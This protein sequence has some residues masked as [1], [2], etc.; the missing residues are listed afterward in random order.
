MNRLVSILIAF[1]LLTFLSYSQDQI[2]FSADATI[3]TCNGFMID[4]GGQGG[5]GYSN[6][7]HVVIT[8][9][10]DTPGEMI[11]AVFNL[12]AL[13]G[14]NTGTQQNPNMD[15]MT[16]YDG[17]STA[18]NTL[19]TY[20]NN[21]L[22]GVVIAATQL[23]TSG[24]LTFEFYSNGVGTGSFAGSI[25]CETPCANPQAGGMLSDGISNDSIRVCIN[26]VVNFQESGSMAQPGFNIVDYNW[27]F[28]DGTTANGQ[29]VSH[30][31]STPG[32]YKVQLFV[33]DDNGCTNPN[34]IDLQVLVAP[35]PDFS[36]LPTDTSIC[37]GEQVTFSAIPDSMQITW[38]GFPGSESVD[39]GCITDE[40]LG[41]SQ[42]IDLMQTGFS[43][44]TVIDNVDDIESICLTMEHSFVGD[45]VILITCPNGQS[46]IL[47]QQGGGGTFLGEPV[48]DDNVD[49]DDPATQGEGYSY[50]FTPTATETWVEYVEGN[51]FPTTLPAGDYESVE[52]LDNLVGCPTNGVWTLSV[53]DNW[54]ADDGTLFE[55]GLTLD[56]SYYPDISSFTPDIGSSV[57][58]SFWINPLF[59]VNTSADGNTLTVEPDAPGVYTYTYEVNDDFGCTNSTTIDLNVDGVLD[60]FAGNDT[61]ACFGDVIQ[62]NGS[63][64]NNGP[65]DLTLNLDDTFGDGWNGN[66]ITVTIGGVATNYTLNTGSTQ[67]FTITANAGE[68]IQVV[69]NAEGNFVSECSF[70]IQDNSGNTLLTQGPNLNG[71]T[72]DNIVSNCSPDYT[73]N[74]SPDNLVND[75]SSL[76]SDY[77]VDTVQTL[78]LEGHITGHPLC[79]SFDTVVISPIPTAHPGID[80]SLTTCTEGP[81]TDLFPLLGANVSTPGTWEDPNG[82]NVTMPYDPITW[83]PGTYTY[84][85]D[86]NGCTASATIEVEELVTA[87]T[88]AV[89][90]PTLCFGSSEGSALITGTTLDSYT[91][92]GTGISPAS[93]PFLIDS[94]SAGNY[95]IQ[96]QSIL[97]CTDDTT[98]TIIEPTA[99]TA[100]SIDVDPLCFNYCD[101]STTITPSG[102]TPGYSFT[103]P[104]GINGNQNGGGLGICAGS[105]TVTITDSNN[106]IFDYEFVLINPDSI[107]PDFAFSTL[108]G[109]EP[110]E[111]EFANKTITTD[112]IVQ[113]YFNFGNGYG[114]YEPGLDSAYHMFG[115]SGLYTFSGTVTTEK[116][117][118]FTTTYTDLIDVLPSPEAAFAISPTPISAYDPIVDITNMSS[119]D[120]LDW[121]WYIPNATPSTS[122]DYHLFDVE[123]PLDTIAHLPVILG[124]VNKFGC[125]DTIVKYAELVDE[126]NLFAPNAFTPNDDA[127]NNT[128]KV[129]LLGIDIYKFDLSIYNQWGELIWRSFDPSVGW[130]GTYNGKKVQM[131]TYTWSINCSDAITDNKYYYNGFVTVL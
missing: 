91:I 21:D 50:C 104:E 60:V 106:C 107:V 129:H 119:N 90:S 84:T 55:F 81:Q 64:V 25:A 73:F 117:C 105:H 131:G 97:G 56:P 18:A 85:V 100:S 75:P 1:Q 53:I 43:S 49:C 38:N 3:N 114:A 66:T 28:M 16:V 30:S 19:G 103:W 44:G 22:Q 93:S 123:F 127:Y 78:I 125:T 12:F 37:L 82:N 95:T 102:G 77:T 6:N 54:A 15:A 59:E 29:N 40:Q 80:S 108:S 42:D 33:T 35:I 8:V 65:C 128:W 121:A 83:E 71:A 26:E 113:T 112:S 13:D 110:L 39:D 98:I 20:N 115:E 9:C 94:L 67:A 122:E 17:N 7:E 11:S 130:D 31:Y 36:S 52:P 5:T 24:C 10:P 89:L 27:D 23:N 63:L 76:T 88:D 126:V 87:I 99:I 46:A 120:V 68:N 86:S 2:S 101:G 109:C 62:L 45:L 124:V 79:N 70:N 47:H 72:N 61:T 14:T 116:G 74:W 4:S 111:V 48:Q 69:F 34:L 51:N 96:V 41:V 57:D 118:E 32:L 92:N 58:S